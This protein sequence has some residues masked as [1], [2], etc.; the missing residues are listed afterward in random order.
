[1]TTAI[2][3]S[4]ICRNKLLS[5]FRYR[6]KFTGYLA[7]TA[8]NASVFVYSMPGFRR[9]GDARDRTYPFAGAAPR[10]FFGDLENY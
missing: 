5:M 10:A 4:T 2:L 1:M 3:T 6:I 9:P 7:Q 8:F